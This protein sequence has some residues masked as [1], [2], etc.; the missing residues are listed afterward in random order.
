VAG[1]VGVWAVVV[2][3]F[4]GAVNVVVSSHIVALLLFV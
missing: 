4:G 2:R 1:A 3:V